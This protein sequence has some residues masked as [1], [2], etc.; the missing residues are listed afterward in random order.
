MTGEFP[1]VP[2]MDQVTAVFVVPDTAV[3]WSPHGSLMGGGLMNRLEMIWRRGRQLE[4]RVTNYRDA[5]QSRYECTLEQINLAAT[6]HDVSL[7]LSPHDGW[8]DGSRLSAFGH[9]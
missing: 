7:N 6:A 4:Q 9:L 2:V 1:A 8:D 3:R 5:P